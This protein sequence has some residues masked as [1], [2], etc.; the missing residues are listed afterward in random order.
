MT[1]SKKEIEKRLNHD[2]SKYGKDRLIITPILDPKDQIGPSGIDLRLGKQFVYFKSHFNPSLN[3][4]KSEQFLPPFNK[5]QEE[6]LV[7]MQKSL[8]LHPGQFILASTF[9]YIGLPGDLEGRIDGRSSWAR[10]GLLIATATTI[11]PHFQGIITLEL[12]NNGTIP[13]EL[14]PGL[15]IAYLTLTKLSDSVKDTKESK[16][17][18]AIGPRHSQIYSDK[19]I[20]YFIPE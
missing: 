15:K 18:Y 17:S 14:Y 13:I 19:D 7:A 8:T 20:K 16:Y 9:E 5:Y 6:I 4:S 11:H 3:P 2:S 12:C 1:I 10:L